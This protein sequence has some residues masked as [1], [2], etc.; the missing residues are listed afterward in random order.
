[1]RGLTQLKTMVTLKNTVI[2][3]EDLSSEIEDRGLEWGQ[4][5]ILCGY[6]CDCIVNPTTLTLVVE[7]L[8]VDGICEIEYSILQGKNSQLHIVLEKFRALHSDRSITLRS[9]FDHTSVHVKMVYSCI[10]KLYHV[11]ELIVDG[12]TETFS[13]DFTSMEIEDILR[14]C[15]RDIQEEERKNA[16]CEK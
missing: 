12:K 6:I 4:D 1:M 11:A 15:Y 5:I 16:N 8:D 10:T 14:K 2:K 9:V 3:K 7:L 13:Q